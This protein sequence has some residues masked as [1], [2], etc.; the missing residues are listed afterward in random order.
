[1][2]DDKTI[3]KCEKCGHEIDGK[4]PICM[5]CGTALPDSVITQETNKRMAEK[6]IDE[7]VKN[8]VSNIGVSLKA[9]GAILIILGLIADIIS[10]FLIFSADFGSYGAITILGTIMFII[11]IAIVSNS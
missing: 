4:S 11:G 1:M 3:I 2:Q 10:M 7:T 9:F 5:H 6:H 8:K